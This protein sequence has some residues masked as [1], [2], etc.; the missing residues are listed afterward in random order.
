VLKELTRTGAGGGLVIAATGF[1]TG[2]N[3]V[4]ILTGDPEEDSFAE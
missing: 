3:G 4:K 2:Q 1:L